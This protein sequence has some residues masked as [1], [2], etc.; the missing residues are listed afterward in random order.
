M[1]II[2]ITTTIIFSLVLGIAANV[3]TPKWQDWWSK[4]S[5]SRAQQGIRRWESR[6]RHTSEL[7]DD[8][9]KF[10][11]YFRRSLIRTILYSVIGVACITNS[12]F[13]KVTG[14]FN[15]VAG[16][17][18]AQFYASDKLG[19]T[20]VTLFFIGGSMLFGTSLALLLDLDTKNKNV[21]YFGTYKVEVEKEIAK[22]ESVI[23]K[24]GGQIPSK[25]SPSTPVV[26]PTKPLS[27]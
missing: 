22:L 2:G 21:A 25:V 12:I 3:L 16:T 7:K 4:T 20:V 27:D 19:D 24:S 9:V 26:P 23:T 6:L 17:K 1:D 13:T 8:Q 10:D 5:V 11:Y 14:L 15:M 18:S